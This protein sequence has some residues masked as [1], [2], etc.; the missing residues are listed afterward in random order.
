MSLL[1]LFQDASSGVA[2]SLP[3]EALAAITDLDE[4]LLE[5]GQDADP[6]PL[7]WSTLSY[8]FAL[9]EDRNADEELQAGGVRSRICRRAGCATPTRSAGHAPAG[10]AADP[11]LTFQADHSVGAGQSGIC[12]PLATRIIRQQ[13][14]RKRR[15][16]CGPAYR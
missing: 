16:F 1:L 8:G 12:G 6:P 11:K 4:A 10:A 7:K 13:R 3:F 2:P 15:T 5:V 9:K 14:M